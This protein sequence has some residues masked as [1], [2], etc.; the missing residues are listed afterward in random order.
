MGT[1]WLGMVPLLQVAKLGNPLKP[2]RV[3]RLKT[4]T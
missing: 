3:L 4:L 2:L 1:A